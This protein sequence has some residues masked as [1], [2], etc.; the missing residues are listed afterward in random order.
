MIDGII[1]YIVS[2]VS[3]FIAGIGIPAVSVWYL[4]RKCP[5]K[6]RR[7]VKRYLPDILDEMADIIDSDEINFSHE[8]YVTKIM[9]AVADKIEDDLKVAGKP[10]SKQDKVKV[11]Q[12]IG[13]VVNG[14]V[15]PVDRLDT[16]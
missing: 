11:E 7:L 8:Q 16:D 2:H 5:L 12:Y 4:N 9:R 15:S 13:R 3:V 1:D 14:F 10:I 6:Y